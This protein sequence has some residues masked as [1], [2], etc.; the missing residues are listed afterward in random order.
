MGYT[1]VQIADYYG[2]TPKEIKTK[3]EKENA[4]EEYCKLAESIITDPQAL[5]QVL[6]II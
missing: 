1:I 6:A 2:R 5:E 3:Q 4:K